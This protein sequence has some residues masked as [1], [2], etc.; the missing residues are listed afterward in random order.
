MEKYI[1]Q[2]FSFESVYFTSLEDKF[3]LTLSSYVVRY[4]YARIVIII[5][6]IGVVI[7][8]VCMLCCSCN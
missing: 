7:T 5:M 6:I 1:D 4:R 3:Y 2:K 8:F